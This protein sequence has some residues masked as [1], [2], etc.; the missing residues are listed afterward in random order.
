MGLFN[1][2]ISSI[3]MQVIKEG[4]KILGHDVGDCLM[5][6]SKIPT[7]IKEKLKVELEKMG[8]L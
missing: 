5:P 4:L 3:E 1:V 6:A 7:D 8:K 2:M